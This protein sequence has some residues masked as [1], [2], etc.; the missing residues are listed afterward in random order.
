MEDYTR[1]LNT[2]LA[3][4]YSPSRTWGLNLDLPL[5]GRHHQHLDTT[6]PAAEGWNFHRLGDAR[7]TDRMQ[8]AQ[9]DNHEIGL[10]MGLKLPTAHPI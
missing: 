7:L 3:L 2:A 10:R 6:V 9:A 8:L 4:D 1:S 5:V